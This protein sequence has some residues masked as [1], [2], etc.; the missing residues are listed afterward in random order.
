MVSNPPYIASAV[1]DTLSPEVRDHEPR[2]A[3][4]GGADGLD[5]VRRLITQSAR[6]LRPSGYIFL[7]IGWDQGHRVAA[8]LEQAGFAGVK[9]HPDLAGHDRMAEG[10]KA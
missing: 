1:C 8:L 2:T 6:V 5:V 7:E 4:D 9:V 10:M 3:L